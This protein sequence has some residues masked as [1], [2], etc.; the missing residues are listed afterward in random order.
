MKRQLL[1][2]WLMLLVGASGV[3]AAEAYTYFDPSD[4][5]LNFCYDDS[6]SSRKNQG[7]TTYNLNTGGATPAWNGIASQV[8]ELYFLMNFENYRP[9]S[10][11][12]WASGMTNLTKVSYINRLNT[13]SVTMM[14]AM[15]GGCKNLTSLDLSGFNTSN[16]TDMNAMFYNCEKLASLNIS[17]FNTAKVTSMYAMFQGCLSLT[18]LNLS[19]FNTSN[20]TDMGY[21]F[22]KCE[23]LESLDLNGF[24]TVKCNNYEYMFYRCLN[25]KAIINTSKFW[26]PSDANLNNMFTSC[27]SLMILQISASM[28]SFLGNSA[29]SG[30]GSASYPCTLL[31]TSDVH[32]SFSTITPD[33]VILKGGYFKSNNIKPYANYYNNTL[34]FYYDD[35]FSSRTGSNMNLN[36]SGT[37]LPGWSVSKTS[38]KSVV[39]DSSFKNARPTWC[40]GWFCGMSNL[41]SL[42]G[43]NNLNTSKV[44]NMSRMFEGCS[45]LTSIDLN[46]SSVTTA[47]VTDM[48]NMFYGC[49]KVT[50]I[51][52]SNFTT[53]N[54]TNMSRM[55]LDCNKLINVNVS[56]FN[57]AKVTDMSRM[58]CNCSSLASINVSNFN[59]SKAS[60]SMD[61]MFYN[62]SSVTDLDLGNFTISSASFILQNCSSL[63]Y[64]KVPSTAN[65]FTSTACSGVGN[66]TNPCLLDYPSGFTPSSTEQGY[67]YYKWRSGFFVDALHPYAVYSSGTLTFYYD[68]SRYSRSG[69]KYSMNTGDAYAL[70][71]LYASSTTSVVFNSSFANARPTSCHTWFSGM[72]NLTSITG[73]SYL[74]TSNVTDMGLMFANCSSFTSLN[75]SSFNTANVTSM[76]GMFGNCSKLASINMSGWNTSKVTSMR[77]MF[78]NC[79]KLT[80]LN[81]SNFNTAK[82]TNM[83]DMF[84]GCSGL[85][86]LDL[87][88]F[89]IP[90]SNTGNM[91]KCSGLKTLTVPSTANNLDASA[92]TGVGTSSN[93]CTLIYPSGFT[94]SVSETGNGWYKWKSGYFKDN[95]DLKGYAVLNGSTLTF[96]YDW[97]S[98]TRT[99]TKYDLNT[100][101]NT[102]GWNAK[103]TSVNKVVF[104]SSFANARPTTCYKWFAG[105]T[106]LTSIEDLEYLNTSNVTNM[107]SMF[108]NCSSLTSLDFSE[109]NAVDFNT[110]K[111]TTMNGMF[112]GCS[113]LTELRFWDDYYTDTD[114]GITTYWGDFYVG[115]VTNMAEMFSGCSSLED[116]ILPGFKPLSSATVTDMFKNCTAAKYLYLDEDLK[117]SP[118]TIFTGL[119]TASK[120]IYHANPEYEPYDAEYISNYFKWKG[121]YFLQSGPGPFVVVRGDV[122]TFRF[123]NRYA[124]DY[125]YDDTYDINYGTNTPEWSSKAASITSVVFDESFAKAHP[126]SCYKWFNGMTKLTDIEGWE[127]LYT[128]DVTNMASMFQGCSSLTS[129]GDIGFNIQTDKVTTMYRMF[130]GCTK[131]KSLDLRDG[132]STST[133]G[134]VLYSSGF[135]T[136]KVTNM[137]QMFYNCKAM[138]SLYIPSLKV[139]SSTAVDEMF[140]N[141]TALNYLLV[142]KDYS[143]APATLF[144][145]IGTASKPCQLSSFHEFLD[146]EP[147]LTY[148]VWKK[149]YFKDVLRRPYAHLENNILSFGYGYDSGGI[150]VDVYDYELNTGSN[151]PAWSGKATTITKVE[152]GESF[153][154]AFPT[155]CYAWFNGMTKLASITGMKYLNTSEVTNMANMF[156]NCKKLTALDIST[157]TLKSGVTSTN[158]MK[159]CTALK[160]LTIPATAGYLN[161]AA[162]TGVGTTTAPCELVCPSGF[163]PERQSSGSGWFQWK[164]GYFKDD[165]PT[166]QYPLGDVNHDGAVTATDAALVTDYAMGNTPPV[167]FSENADMNGDGSITVTD[168]STIV[169][170]VLGGTPPT[171]PT[172]SE[173][174][175]VD[176]GLP[177]GTLWAD[178]NVGASSPDGYGKFFAWGETKTKATYSWSNYEYCSGSQSTCQSLGTHIAGTQYDAAT[179]EWGSGWVMPTLDQA[180]ELLTKCTVSKTTVNDIP[181]LRF[182]GPNGNSIFFPMTGYK[183][184]SNYSEEGTQTYLWTDTKD[185]VTNVAYK[186]MAL[187]MERSTSSA[188]ANTQAAPRRSGVVIRAVRK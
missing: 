78:Y 99:G 150:S 98:A 8:K 116:F 143:N 153:K 12:R 155:S 20:V 113:K 10:C 86:S 168:V 64:L 180:N 45:N 124:Y 188:K 108:L 61:Y 149:G 152:F 26:F 39:I 125:S 187:Y 9:T 55:F 76:Y 18:S 62:C 132:S 92:C 48:S 110:G 184:D 179:K 3:R 25:L 159:N 162:C 69:Y 102:P 117:D 14:Y 65:N 70:W 137:K 130:Y 112:K 93:P 84:N 43:F 151:T 80:S 118:S 164:G 67:G 146:A 38:V 85:T 173:H 50:N 142:Q 6:R 105:M 128:N 129:L 140:Q 103:A 185:N 59:T 23:K 148:I 169:S 35:Y 31:Y 91:I 81:L 17:N 89:T 144:S 36:T 15:F 109:A 165:T 139:S 175:Y 104:N 174:T 71:N 123:G 75:L 122:M 51:L 131:L 161:N 19:S 83:Q 33:Y 42:T 183:Y 82:V 176:L 107:A 41:T 29:F 167:F 154:F 63:T 97:S 5:S 111:V 1:I 178:C 147:H 120:P 134:P 46:W 73:L 87:S 96:Y 47:N 182:K 95:G 166:Q 163:T 170:M 44:T 90:S 32:P 34:T 141:C 127:Y 121:G 77:Q 138:T 24:N 160:K 49:S 72:T 74:N 40:Y 27:P 60:S 172:P 58:F 186:S 156:Q 119:G 126:T 2:L 30:I 13:S 136:D 57:T 158:M 145:G 106:A 171:P 52:I 22:Y 28:S 53:T 21:M 4:G 66:S 181:G 115:K 54:V 114:E 37:A 101:T 56:G 7:Y 177:S 16:V 68:K 135:R 94:P 79:P 11:C 88:K 133:G 157:F 100:G